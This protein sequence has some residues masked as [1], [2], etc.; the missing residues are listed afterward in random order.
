MIAGR[1]KM[2]EDARRTELR[3]NLSPMIAKAIT[4]KDAKAKGYRPLTRPLNT[5]CIFGV[6]TL[7][8]VIRDLRAVPH[9]LVCVKKDTY[10]VWRK[11]PV[12]IDLKKIKI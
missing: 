11:M 8:S 4:P 6:E 7:L 2:D 12:Q 5:Y 3:A 10:E 9:D 1:S